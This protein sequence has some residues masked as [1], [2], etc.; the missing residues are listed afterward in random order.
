MKSSATWI[1]DIVLV[2]QT[3]CNT[4]KGEVLDGF[5]QRCDVHPD[6]CMTLQAEIQL[7][8]ISNVAE[9]NRFLMI[10]STG[11]LVKITK[12]MNLASSK[13]I[14]RLICIVFKSDKYSEEVEKAKYK[15]NQIFI[16]QF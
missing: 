5:I 2:G 8:A 14:F 3:F 11:G 4:M 15:L 16:F 9:Q 7:D 10:D 13:D 1:N 6:F 12:H